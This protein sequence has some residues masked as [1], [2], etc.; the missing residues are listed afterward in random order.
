MISISACART[1]NL[2]PG[3]YTYREG[4]HDSGIRIRMR[5]HMR[6]QTREIPRPARGIRRMHMEGIRIR[7]K[8]S[9][10]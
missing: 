9:Y 6:T 8:K 1:L 5:M 10:L 3:E 4:D 2:E 7:R